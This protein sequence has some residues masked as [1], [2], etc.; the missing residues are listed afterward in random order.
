M[1]RYRPIYLEKL[2]LIRS[3]LKRFDVD[4][5]AGNVSSPEATGAFPRGSV[6]PSRD[7][8]TSHAFCIFLL[9]GKV[10]RDGEG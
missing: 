4:R 2:G 5:T 6:C 1:L 8:Y 9:P 7:F 3:S 10:F